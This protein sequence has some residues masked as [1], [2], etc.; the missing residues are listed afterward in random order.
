MEKYKYLEDLTPPSQLVAS[1]DDMQRSSQTYTT[2]PSK[3]RVMSKLDQL[4]TY[5]RVPVTGRID[6]ATIEAMRR[7]R[8]G[9]ADPDIAELNETENEGEIDVQEEENSGRR[10]KQK[11]RRHKRYALA[12]D[13]WSKKHITYRIDNYPTSVWIPRK[14]VQDSI[15]RALQMWSD[16][17]PLEFRMLDDWDIDDEDADIYVS[18]SKYR[19]GDPYPFDGP[20]GTI[21]HAYLPNGQFGDLDGDVHFDDSE[22]FSYD[23][24][25][26]YNLFKVAAHE[27]GHS[28]GLE[29]SH[30]MGSI[31]VPD[32]AG[33]KGD[34]NE[35]KL[36]D[37]D[38][39][40]IQ[41]LY[42]DPSIPRYKG[43]P[44]AECNK[45]FDATALIDGTLFV[46]RDR[47]FWR[48]KKIG[49]IMSPKKGEKIA[50]RF[51]KMP[52]KIDTVYQRKDGHIVALKGHLMWIYKGKTLLPGFPRSVRTRNMPGRV[53]AA[54]HFRAY[55]KT[56]FFRGPYVWRY[57]EKREYVDG[58]FPRLTKDVFA[59]VQ[60]PVNAAFQYT[61]KNL[62][63]LQRKKYQKYST[64]H[65]SADPGYPRYFG[66][67]FIMCTTKNYKSDK[68]KQAKVKQ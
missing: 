66:E 12:G 49:K 16:V 56:Y 57:D 38:I 32:Y 52:H 11:R 31:M 18:F 63:F 45:A 7:P 23:G 6:E 48:L 42:G 55:N 37:D 3:K 20:D 2:T 9:R 26:G 17:T 22:Y 64:E 25:S 34:D 67:D 35:F 8:C 5:L 27:L 50:R 68:S 58:G 53:D 10:K 4:Q 30:T 15:S 65:R 1:R 40:A 62:Y 29:H 60:T 36:G 28:L 19:H 43:N 21:A 24:E 61:D 14:K 41:V 47:R 13:R 33:F 46:F 54:L 39:R 44:R 59:G 51:P